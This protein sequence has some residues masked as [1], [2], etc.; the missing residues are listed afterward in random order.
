LKKLVVVKA[1]T[2]DLGLPGVGNTAGVEISGGRQTFHF[3][4]L[5]EDE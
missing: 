2:D 4:N 1:L 5:S 3:G